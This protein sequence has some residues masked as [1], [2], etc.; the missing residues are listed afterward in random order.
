MLDIYPGKKP[1]FVKNFMD[2]SASIRAAI[3]RFVTEVR[4]ALSPVPSTASRERRWAQGA[5]HWVCEAGHVRRSYIVHA[6]K[7][8][9]L[10]PSA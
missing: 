10:E 7:L 4:P 5:R 6:S 9:S 3:E 2:G 8:K 1:R